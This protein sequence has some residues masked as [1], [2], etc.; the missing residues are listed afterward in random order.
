MSKTSYD[1]KLFRV[2]RADGAVTTVSV[3][4]ELFEQACDVMGGVKPV[5]DYVREVALECQLGMSPSCSTRVASSLRQ[6]IAQIR[7]RQPS[8]S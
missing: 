5:A 8:A 4:S 7:A 1:Y 3:T 2:R 6:R